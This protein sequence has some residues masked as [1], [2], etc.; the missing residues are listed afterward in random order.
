MVEQTPRRS[1]E[2]RASLRHGGAKHLGQVLLA[3]RVM[4]R[5]WCGDPHQR[6]SA[7]RSLTSS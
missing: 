1:A 2:R 7:L 3:C 5:E 4:A 6:F